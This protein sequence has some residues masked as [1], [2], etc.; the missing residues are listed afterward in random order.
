MMQLT[1][2]TV[3]YDP[4]YEAGA[5]DISNESSFTV[6]CADIDEAVWEITRRDCFLLSSY[7]DL[8]PTTWIMTEPRKHPYSGQYEETTCHRGTGISN[9]Q[10]LDIL[11]RVQGN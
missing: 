1:F 10:W 5:H 11:R 3:V 7:P 9:E 4:D 6:E 8:M 2:Y